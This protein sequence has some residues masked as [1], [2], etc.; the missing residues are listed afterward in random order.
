MVHDAPIS[1]LNRPELGMIVEKSSLAY[2]VCLSQPAGLSIDRP[3]KTDAHHQ[4]VFRWGHA[5]RARAKTQRP[6]E[7]PPTVR[8]PLRSEAKRNAEF[9]GTERRNIV[10]RRARLSRSSHCRGWPGSPTTKCLLPDLF[11]PGTRT[12]IVTPFVWVFRR[13]SPM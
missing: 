7:P 12:R 2:V 4:L 1:L 13:P 11:I 10:L 9:P 8:P 6:M 3:H 5:G